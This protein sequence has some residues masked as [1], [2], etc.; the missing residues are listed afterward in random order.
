MLSHFLQ[1]APH[2]ARCVRA[3]EVSWPCDA[4]VKLPAALRLL[5]RLR[6]LTLCIAGIYAP[7][8]VVLGADGLVRVD[9][10]EN[11]TD[12]DS[13]GSEGIVLFDAARVW[14]H[15]YPLAFH[16]T[17]DMLGGWGAPQRMVHALF[18]FRS[19]DTPLVDQGSAA[20]FSRV[21]RNILYPPF[22]HAR[23]LILEPSFC[24]EAVQEIVRRLVQQHPV[25]ALAVRGVERRTG[26]FED[27]YVWLHNIAGERFVAQLMQDL[28]VASELKALQLV[29]APYAPPD[30]LPAGFARCV[31]LRLVRLSGF[32]TC[33]HA[34]ISYLHALAHAPTLS[35]LM[36]S[37]R[38]SLAPRMW[39][40]VARLYWEAVDEEIA[41]VLPR[42]RVIVDLIVE[43]ERNGMGEVLMRKM[44]CAALCGMVSVRSAN[45]PEWES[46]G[47]VEMRLRF[48][49]IQHESI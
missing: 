38:T 19:V 24:G 25:Q 11:N 42:V 13:I 46:Y 27:D 10:S 29:C 36:L 43:A 5:P 22:M 15:A 26:K 12:S 4:H 32:W 21:P 9:S 49:A 8:R 47:D 34:A 44:R 28:A 30:T 39:I 33:A 20:L 35:V 1:D 45:K 37:L 31:H 41:A 48:D 7:D 16:A 17:G 14:M 3:L 2:A 18:L 6:R 23:M 40:A